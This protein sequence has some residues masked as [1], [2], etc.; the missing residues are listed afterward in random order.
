MAGVDD[1]TGGP[2]R[3][4][5]LQAL[6]SALGGVVLSGAGI[7]DA[8]GAQIPPGQ[9]SG[10]ASIPNG[11]AFYRV[12]TTESLVPWP[13]NP[14]K[15]NPI[16]DLTGVV[17]MAGTTPRIFLHAM[18]SP[19]GT[20]SGVPNNPAPNA[21]LLATMNY[22]Q[23]PSIADLKVVTYEGQSL[24][25][26]KV[27]GAASELLPIRMDRLG[28]GDTNNVGQYA[29]TI[30]SQDLNPTVA[31]NSAPGVYVYTPE[32]DRWTQKARFGDVL[33]DGSEYG[34]LFGD[35][36]LADDNSV[37]FSAGTTQAATGFGGT[38]A[39]MVAP[40]SGGPLSHRVVMKT[41][42]MLPGTNAVIDGIGLIDT[43][44]ADGGLVAQVFASRRNGPDRDLGSALV[45]GNISQGAGSLQLLAAS[46]HLVAQQAN[47]MI[48]ET[49]MGPRIANGGVAGYI[50]HTGSLQTTETLRLKRGQRQIQIEQT[51]NH[52]QGAAQRAVAA[53]NAPVISNGLMFDTVVLQDGATALTITD[54]QTVRVLLT[55]GDVVQG[56]QITQILFGCHP[57]N[58]DSNNRLAFA[59]EFLKDAAANPNDPNN[60]FSALVVGIPL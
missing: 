52:V 56:L 5:F 58:V 51:G 35:V 59:A 4:Q 47:V 50:T 16:A 9:A 41:G 12:V 23:T 17:L 45:Q 14:G 60:V 20:P 27:S 48:G 53:M 28:T 22:S 31:I 18:L 30:T 19:A 54:G 8:L 38:Q 2:T 44:G 29:T 43:S 40:P 24:D 57:R 7:T 49:I 25:G 39:L 34:G 1:P 21:L 55:S 13:G 42:D 37:I 3:R 26:S 32:T 15:I 46:S 10:T 11:Y 6:G 36:A 33:Q